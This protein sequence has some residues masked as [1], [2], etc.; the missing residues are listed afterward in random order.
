[1]CKRKETISELYSLVDSFTQNQTVQ[2]P[3]LCV[4][5]YLNDNIHKSILKHLVNFHHTKLKTIEK[6]G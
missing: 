2:N 3:I 6:D 5:F 1:M 4:Y